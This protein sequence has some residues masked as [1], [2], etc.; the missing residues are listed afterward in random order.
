MSKIYV[1]GT[2]IGN[3]SDITIRALEILKNVPI[4]ASWRHKSNSKITW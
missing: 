3:L 1:V 2:P 4:I